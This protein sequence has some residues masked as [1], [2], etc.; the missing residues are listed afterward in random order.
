MENYIK[1]SGL[2]PIEKTSILE[3]KKYKPS[4]VLGVINFLK[5]K[6]KKEN[7]DNKFLI[8]KDY[9]FV[10]LNY[11]RKYFYHSNELTIKDFKKMSGITRKT[12][13][14]LEHWT[15]LGIQYVKKIFGF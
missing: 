11:L 3:L 10:L 6:N 4:E 1:N 2:V 12:T 15:K 8:H 9:F 13:T 5:S 7:I 14:L